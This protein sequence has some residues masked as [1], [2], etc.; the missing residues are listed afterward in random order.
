MII[1]IPIFS[2]FSKLKILILIIIFSSLFNVNLFGQQ[3]SKNIIEDK[4]ISNEEI[5]AGHEGQLKPFDLPSIEVKNYLYGKI[6]KEVRYK[7][8]NFKIMSFDHKANNF[9]LNVIPTDQFGNFIENLGSKDFDISYSLIR[10][11]IKFPSNLTFQEEKKLNKD[12]SEINVYFLIDNSVTSGNLQ[13]AVEQ[14]QKAIQ[15]FQIKDNSSITLFNNKQNSVSSLSPSKLVLSNLTSETLH[16]EGTNSTGNALNFSLNEIGQNKESLKNIIILITNSSDNATLTGSLK[17]SIEKARELKVPI[18]TI[19][20]G[21]DIRSYQLVPIANATGGRFYWM[22]NSQMEDLSSVINEIYYGNK[23]YYRFKISTNVNLE[24]V[25]DFELKLSLY[26]GSVFLDDSVYIYLKAPEMF[27]TNKI[28]ALYDKN[29][30][31]FPGLYSAQLKEIADYLMND[32]S[33]TAEI[34]GYSDN[35]TNDFE[36]DRL[37][38]LERAKQI[39]DTLIKIGVNK[40]QLKIKGKGSSYPIYYSPKNEAQE[41]YNRRTEIRWIDSKLSPNEIVCEKAISEFEAEQ[42]IKKWEDVGYKAFYLR[43][44]ENGDVFY[45]VIL[46]GFKT[47]EQTDKEL[48]KLKSTFNNIDFQIE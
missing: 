19:G 13:S 34:T 31:K 33:R 43:S 7:F 2:G 23:V 38:S 36:K 41:S 18:Y 26:N 14:V 39:Q 47:E 30:N 4:Q 40:K 32:F 42:F 9:Y 6:P 12:K 5:I 46:W 11:F 28:V 3:E 35:E 21:T 10:D 8:S 22:E 48:D 24:S 27:T 15:N 45:R 17:E 16:S 37:L 1:N 44:I 20:I 25:E 29:E